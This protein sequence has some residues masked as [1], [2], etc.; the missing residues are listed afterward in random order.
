MGVMGLEREELK[1]VRRSQAPGQGAGVKRRR[2]MSP[3]PSPVPGPISWDGRVEAHDPGWPAEG[4]PG[5]DL[6]L[7]TAPWSA[8]VLS[9]PFLESA[10]T[11]NPNGSILAS[12]LG[13][14]EP[15]GDKK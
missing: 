2:R 7:S 10:G 13:A 9:G 6:R 11:C 12:P 3:R 8:V 1:M 5:T 15:R 14:T 4:A